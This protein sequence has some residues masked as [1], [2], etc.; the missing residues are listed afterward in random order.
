M[1]ASET[2]VAYVDGELDAEK[3]AEVEAAA[4]T[5]PALAEAIAAHRSLRDGLFAAFAPI[6]EEPVPDRLVAAA[7]PPAPVIS[8]D[9]FRARRKVL[10]QVGAMAASLVAAVGVTLLVTQPHGDFRS[11]PGGLLAQGQLA[12]ALSSQLA[13]DD[14]GATRIGLTFRDKTG[15]VCRTFSTKASD[16]MA[17]RDGDA[18]R[19]DALAR[20]ENATEFRQAASPLIMTAAEDR[21]TGDAFDADAEK[22]A[23]DKGWK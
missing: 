15:A 6:A 1:I 14:H 7:V 18:W 12:Q 3:A 21:M 16:G 13:S 22:A 10:F 4:K 19:V 2:I 11:G 8:L 9:A 5:D 23:R 20:A 17:C